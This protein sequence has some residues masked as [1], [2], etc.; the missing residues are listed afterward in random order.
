MAGFEQD[1]ETL[2]RLLR[3]QRQALQQ[4]QADK[5][6]GLAPLIDEYIRRVQD[7]SPQLAELEPQARRRLSVRI[8]GLLAEVSRNQAAWQAHYQDLMESREELKAARRYAQ[9]MQSD[10]ALLSRRL[11]T[12]A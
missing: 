1:Y 12:T 7:R 11:D 2:E 9:S 8:S 3:S 4:G 6:A 5:L 10:P